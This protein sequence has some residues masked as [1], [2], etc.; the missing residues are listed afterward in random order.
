M[1]RLLTIKRIGV[2]LKL[3][4]SIVQN[5]KIGR[6]KGSGLEL[7]SC[8]SR[9]FENLFQDKTKYKIQ[10]Y[11]VETED[12]YILTVFRVNLTTAYKFVILAKEI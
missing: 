4:L 7:W 8:S 2:I 10:T 11:Q 6:D 12:G 5:W 1:A 9:N 3:P